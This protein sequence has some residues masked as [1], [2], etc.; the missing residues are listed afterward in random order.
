[1][2]VIP[3]EI[4]EAS[5]IQTGSDPIKNFAAKPKQQ[6]IKT[7]NQLQG[8]INMTYQ[9][10]FC[11]LYWYLNPKIKSGITLDKNEVGLVTMSLNMNSGNIRIE[12]FKDV[13]SMMHDGNIFL[14]KKNL[15]CHAAIYPADMYAIRRASQDSPPDFAHICTEQLLTPYSGMDW[16]NTLS[17]VIITMENNTQLGMTIKTAQ[18]ETYTYNFDDVQYEMFLHTLD[19]CLSTGLQLTG[20]QSL[21]K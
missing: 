7:N 12:L 8:E 18:D 10:N 14:D 20:M 17:K 1:M 16:Q 19:F 2:T 21:K 4:P 5:Q 3:F 6:I 15:S 13:E 11:N 9:T